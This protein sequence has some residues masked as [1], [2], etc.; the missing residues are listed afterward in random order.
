[1]G[2]KEEEEEDEETAERA[3]A[4]AEQEK[5]SLLKRHLLRARDPLWGR[6]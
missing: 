5:L 4:L 1:M 3:R 6:D 2:E